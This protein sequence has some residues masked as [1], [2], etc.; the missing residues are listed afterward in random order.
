[1]NTKEELQATFRE[2][3]AKV[4]VGT[5]DAKKASGP[6]YETPAWT[7]AIAWW[8]E[9]GPDKPPTCRVLVLS[10]GN[11]T[12]KTLAMCRL[13]RDHVRDN[14]QRSFYHSPGDMPPWW[15]WRGA[16][17][18]EARHVAAIDS[19]SYEGSR[20][21]KAI[22]NA[23]VLLLDEAGAE[24]GDAERTI[25]ALLCERYSNEQLRTVVATNLSEETFASRYGKRF[26]SRLA[27]GGRFKLVHA[28]D[29]RVGES[30][31]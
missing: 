13:L 20:E 1:M 31:G 3:L 14:S 23:H 11:G 2:Y 18:R 16:L 29:L 24:D 8:T 4:G 25:G 9:H 19:R 7:D 12:G 15:I 5:D 6:M 10:G 21:L 30:D 17:Y 27:G 28:K 22:E 26:A